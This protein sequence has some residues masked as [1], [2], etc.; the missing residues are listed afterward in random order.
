MDE[1]FEKLYSEFIKKGL[2]AGFTDDQINFMWEYV[3][4]TVASMIKMKNN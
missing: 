1:E 3:M 2:N 4:L